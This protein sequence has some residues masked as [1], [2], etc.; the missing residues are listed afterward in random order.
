MK[1]D[2]DLIRNLLLRIEDKTDGVTNFYYQD[3]VGNHFTT[4]PTSAVEY[5]IKFLYD[6]GFV[7]CPRSSHLHIIDITP[8]GRDYLDNVRN[9][10]IWEKT[11]DKANSLGPV[12]LDVIKE[13]AKSLILGHLGLK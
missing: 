12:T 5:H 6:S 1:L 7:Q 9:V 11:K 2:Y 8:K 4:V 3:I 13:L 10:D